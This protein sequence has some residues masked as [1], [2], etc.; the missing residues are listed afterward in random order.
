MELNQVTLPSR[1]LHRAIP[2]YELLGLELIVDS[3]P[4]YAR[5]L[6]PVGGATLSLHH[7]ET[8]AEGSTGI[9]LYFEC[10]DLDAEYARL[11]AAGVPFASPPVE[12]SWLWREAW[13]SDPDGNRLCLYHAG[14]NRIDPP[15]R[16]AAQ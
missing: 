10:A 16:V 12:Q 15:W 14:K 11:R 13:F 3:R 9:H 6:L 4:R 5:F 7:V 1:D 8:L 2:F